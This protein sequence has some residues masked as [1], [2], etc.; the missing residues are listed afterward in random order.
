METLRVLDRVVVLG[1][2]GDTCSI[3]GMQY[4]MPSSHAVP[5][6]GHAV[7]PYAH[8]YELSPCELHVTC[9]P[10]VMCRGVETGKELEMMMIMNPLVK[11]FPFPRP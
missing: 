7:Q 9:I 8:A 5:C 6:R 3:A 11:L 1:P 10:G 2:G 4:D